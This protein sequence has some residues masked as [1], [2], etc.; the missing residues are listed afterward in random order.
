MGNGWAD[1]DLDANQLMTVGEFFSL[2]GDT[3]WAQ[4]WPIPSYRAIL[5][6]LSALC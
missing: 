5:P 1:T 3:Q 2:A 4:E 6:L